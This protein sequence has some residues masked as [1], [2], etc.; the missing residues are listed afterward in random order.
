MASIKNIPLKKLRKFLE[1]NGLQYSHTNGGH[2]IWVKEGLSRP[3]VLQTHIAPVPPHIIKQI[4]RH[5][6]V[7]NEDLCNY[8]DSL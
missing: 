5:L 6:N 2:E 3:I 4:C 1:A 7:T 8:I